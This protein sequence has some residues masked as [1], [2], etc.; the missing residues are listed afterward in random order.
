MIN[1]VLLPDC[2][3][4][5]HHISMPLEKGPLNKLSLPKPRPPRR[6][7]D[8]LPLHPDFP[9]PLTPTQPLPPPFNPPRQPNRRR[10]PQ[11][12]HNTNAHQPHTYQITTAIL[13]A[14]DLAPGVGLPPRVQ[15]VRGDDAAQV[16]EPADQGRGGRD[17]D[18][19]VARG[20]DLA[21]PG[22]GDGD[23]GAEAEA[24]Y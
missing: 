20:E 24:D 10:H 4:Y 8:L 2:L 22:H 3:L 6:R 5:I 23:G 19:A 18:L 7:P 1:P 17:A 21:R 11:T 13:L 16:A 12:S 9:D 15:G 14:A